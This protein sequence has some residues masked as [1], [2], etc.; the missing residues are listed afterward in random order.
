ML[1]LIHLFP[2]LYS[3]RLAFWLFGL[4]RLFC[5]FNSWSFFSSSNPKNPISLL[6]FACA[7][8]SETTALAIIIVPEISFFS[9]NSDTFPSIM[10]E[11]SGT[12]A[13]I[14]LIF[15]KVFIYLFVLVI[16]KKS[17]ILVIFLVILSNVSFAKVINIPE[18]SEGT[19]SGE[20]SEELPAPLEE[21]IDYAKGITKYYY[22]GNSL[23]YSE[24][25]DLEE[26]SYFDE[27]KFYFQD[28]LGS[29]RIT[30][31]EEGNVKNFKSLPYG[32]VIQDGV[33]Y[34]FTGKEKDESGLHY[35]SARYYDS[36]LGRFTSVDPVKEN[37]PYSYVGNNP[38]MF[39]D[40]DGRNHLQGLIGLPDLNDVVR[41][42]RFVEAV[43]S[44]DLVNTFRHQHG[45]EV[46][47]R[48]RPGGFEG[49]FMSHYGSIGADNTDVLVHT[50]PD[51]VPSKPS[52]GDM[53][54]PGTRAVV[55][56]EGTYLFNE[57]STSVDIDLGHGKVDRRATGVV[58][59]EEEVIFRN[60]AEGLE[61]HPRKGTS[62]GFSYVDDALPSSA[63]IAIRRG[64]NSAR[65][66]FATNPA[67]IVAGRFAP[68]LGVGLD[69]FYSGVQI[70][71]LNENI[72]NNEVDVISD[73]NEYGA[74][75][76]CH[77]W[78][79]GL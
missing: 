7:S 10:A 27:K 75:L 26:Y 70:G 3:P 57:R 59:I 20:D 8:S 39:V 36:D 64:A 65:H 43:S 76:A 14:V 32:Q 5:F 74:C 51:I 30:I 25:D 38:M 71:N 56:E 13:F 50:H 69:I 19:L 66:F 53:G 15:G 77:K 2:Y 63:E 58:R 41:E 52:S 68:V 24:Y 55:S 12:Y 67:G 35:F 79:H 34:G 16:M 33:Q 72:M 73:I 42:A 60:S 78:R 54:L 40:P 18:V 47:L 28:R 22:S 1:L 49:D 48:S 62:I 61:L 17:V 46:M 31:D 45:Q 6:L 11:V 29:N 21:E 9:I 44:H 4:L 37:E 23:V